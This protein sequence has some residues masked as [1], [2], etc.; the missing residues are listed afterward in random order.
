VN[1]LVIYGLGSFARMMRHYF[2]DDS[3]FT[4]VAFCADR[5]H[6]TTET[7]DGLPVVPFEDV[8]TKFPCDAFTMFVAVGYS[9]M[10]TRPEMYQK[11]KSK[12]YRFTNYISSGARIDQSSGMGVNNVVLAGSQIEPFCKIGDNNIIW[13]SVNICH[14]SKIADHCFL[15]SQS[16]IGGFSEVGANSFIGFNATIIQNVTLGQESLV[17]SK[18]LVLSD[19]EP[20][21]K[22]IGVPAKAAGF[23]SA[24]GIKIK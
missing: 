8:E 9:S 2:D 24:E 10:R 22:N 21:S 23:H 11:A 5:S 6:L 18:S 16:L 12:G 15:A 3:L 14:D 1:A 17:G 13:T 19:T 4:V 7:F 20:F